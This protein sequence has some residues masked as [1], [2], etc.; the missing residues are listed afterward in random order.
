M[1]RAVRHGLGNL[2]IFEGRDARQAFWYYVLMVYIATTVLTMLVTVPLTLSAVFTSVSEVIQQ[3]QYNQDPAAVEVA[4]QGS[5]MR[6]MDKIIPLTVTLGF[7]TTVLMIVLLGASFVRRLHDSDLSG[8]W[9]LVPAGLQAI[10]LF[11]IPET[12]RTMMAAMNRL[13]FGDPRAGFAMMRDSIGLGA[14]AGLATTII[15]IVLGVRTSTEGPNV[16][17]EAPF[18]A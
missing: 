13:Q 11:M 8:Y 15:V 1:L 4:M 16:Y 9:A 10:G 3:S 6:A 14:L 5:M 7:V 17:G 18:T 2:L 12:M